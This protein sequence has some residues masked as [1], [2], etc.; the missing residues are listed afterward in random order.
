MVLSLHY[1]YLISHMCGTK[2]NMKKK[3]KEEEKKKKKIKQ[4]NTY[5]VAAPVGRRGDCLLKI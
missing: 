3:K 4:S 1:P 2:E 5:A